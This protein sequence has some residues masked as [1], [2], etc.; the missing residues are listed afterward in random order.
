MKKI[1]MILL[2]ALLTTAS[3][4]F[5]TPQLATPSDNEQ[6]YQLQEFVADFTKYTIGDTAPALYRSQKYNIKQWQAR[7]L[8]AP[9]EG[10][11]W[12]YMGS[13]YV[14]ITDTDGKII[15]AYDGNIYY[16]R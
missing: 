16:Q 7:N 15:K 5:A 3:A 11:H 8:P 12:T 4:A 2:G 9:D 14:L 1:K 13:N 10:T 6:K